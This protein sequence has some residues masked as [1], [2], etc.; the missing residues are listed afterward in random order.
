M[1]GW[2]SLSWGYHGD[3]GKKYES[4]TGAIYGETFTTGDV[5]GCRVHLGADVAFAKNG[6]SLGV[7]FRGIS[8]KL[9]PAVG[10]RS[11]GAHVR[12]NF[13]QRPFLRNVIA[14]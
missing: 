8:G 6:T 11:R 1:P 10:I 2:T 13:G 14:C 4:G 3:D 5:I 12:V 7:A 9:Y